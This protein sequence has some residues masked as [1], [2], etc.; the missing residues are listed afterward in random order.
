MRIA[1]IDIETGGFSKEK[2]ALC[3]IGLIIT[4]GDKVLVEYSSTVSPYPRENGEPVSYKDD[5]MAIHGIT[6]DDINRSK[7][8]NIVLFEVI[9]ALKEFN[10]T[11]IGGHNIKQFDIPW[12]NYLMMRFNGFNFMGYELIDTLEMA[13]KRYTGSNKMEDLCDMLGITQGNHRAL[14]DAEAS[15]ELYKL[16]R[17]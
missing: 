17:R 4:E 14:G 11:A 9:F 1:F 3:E 2:N 15:F 12:L 8:I 7:P 6:M 5:A 16:L 10:V 13:R